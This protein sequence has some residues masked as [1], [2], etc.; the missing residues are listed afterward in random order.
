MQK[1]IEKLLIAVKQGIQFMGKRKYHMK[2]RRV[3]HLSTTFVHPELLVDGLA[4]RAVSVS[5]G[6]IVEFQ[7]AAVR[8]LGN[9]YPKIPGF[10][11][12]DSPGSFSLN[13]RQ[14]AGFFSKGQIRSLPD[15]LDFRISHGTSL[16]SCRKD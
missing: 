8:A 15:L 6:V 14:M 10:A 5:A 7:M 2:V 9:V 4:V 13:I 3:N 1:G 12:E 16:P 11:V